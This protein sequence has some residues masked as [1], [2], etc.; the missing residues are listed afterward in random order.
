MSAHFVRDAFRIYEKNIG[1]METALKSGPWLCGEQ[2][3][4]ADIA[5][6]PY[7]HRMDRLGL[8]RYWEPKRPRVGD[9]LARMRARPSFDTAVVAFGQVDVFNDK[10]DGVDVWPEVEK[11]LAS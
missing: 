4:L 9:W 5:V 10:F 8:A 2:F 11:A 1:D 6:V 3:T 7:L